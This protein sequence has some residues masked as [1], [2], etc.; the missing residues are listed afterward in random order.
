MLPF[1]PTLLLKAIKINKVSDYQIKQ[2]KK[3]ITK[4]NVP[5]F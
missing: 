5:S 3:S 1:S 4:S 2:I